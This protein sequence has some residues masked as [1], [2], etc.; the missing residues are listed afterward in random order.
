MQAYRAH[1]K[2]HVFY[3]NVK[4]TPYSQMPMFYY[5]DIAID[6]PIIVYC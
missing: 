4:N 2:S 3:F 6:N 5:I 1:I